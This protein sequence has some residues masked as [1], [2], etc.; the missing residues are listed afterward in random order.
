MDI[1]NL[2]PSKNAPSTLSQ[3]GKHPKTR[4]GMCEVHYFSM[5]LFLPLLNQGIRASA[6]VPMTALLTPGYN[7]PIAV[8]MP[9]QGRK[10]E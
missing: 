9:V 1:N 5:P 2:P 8:W 7:F 4:E 6:I 10:H 3:W